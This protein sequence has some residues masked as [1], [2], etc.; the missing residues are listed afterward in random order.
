MSLVVCEML[1][2]KSLLIE[3]KVLRRGPLK[4][5]CGNK[6]AI[7]IPNNPVQHDRTKHVEIDQFF[8]K[9]KRDDGTLELYYV[10]SRG[11]ITDCLTKGL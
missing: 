10:N 6:S 7:N 2:L 1:W 5:W 11:Q 8:I 4:I 9:E 3:L